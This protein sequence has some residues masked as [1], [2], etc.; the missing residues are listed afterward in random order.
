MPLLID[1]EVGEALGRTGRGVDARCCCAI[2][3]GRTQEHS[4]GM[5]KWQVADAVTALDKPPDTREILGRAYNCALG[6]RGGE[7]R[8][9]AQR[10][11]KQLGMDSV[12]GNLVTR[13]SCRVITC[14]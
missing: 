1:M 14:W 5:A 9:M 10:H 8:A 4:A 3:Y 13:G 12:A 11:F 2:M 7:R 6:Q